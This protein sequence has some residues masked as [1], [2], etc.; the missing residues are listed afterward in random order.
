MP[1][2][3]RRV[4]DSVWQKGPIHKP[5]PASATDPL[6]GGYARLRDAMAAA[7]E[8]LRTDILT[9]AYMRDPE[10]TPRFDDLER[11]YG[12]KNDPNLS[13]QTR[14][15]NL[16][17]A[18][19]AKRTTAQIDEL[20]RRIRAAGF[21]LYCYNNSPE[22]PPIDPALILDASFSMQAMYSTNYY[23]G[24]T[25]AQAGRAGGYWLVNGPI[26]YQQPGISGAGT[27]WADGWNA[28]A[29]FFTG[30]VKTPVEYP[31]PADS[32]DWPFV[33]F[34]G[35]V[36]TFAGDGSILTIAQ[37]LVPSEQQKQLEEIILKFK[38]AYAWAG[39]V[40]TYN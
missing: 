24:N 14:I 37:G 38:G 3:F 34:V 10:R 25:F 1:S 26:F 31:T 27:M 35:G 33:I 32:D 15:D 9:L 16:K 6:A 12:I 36:A 23:A 11:D 29:G 20:Q 8:Y 4:I 17:V 28:Y 19:Y 39:M 5:K 22:G 21:D 13:P 18:R 2:F 40:I 7:F 30:L